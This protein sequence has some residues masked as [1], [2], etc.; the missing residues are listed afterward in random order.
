MD[1]QAPYFLVDQ[2]NQEH[3]RKF[4]GTAINQKTNLMTLNPNASYLYEEGKHTHMPQLTKT[5][6]KELVDSRF[7]NDM[8]NP[9]RG[10]HL[11]QGDLHSASGKFS[12]SPQ[13]LKRD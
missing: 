4:A 10:A 12:A 1:G 9:K 11:I 8:L 3:F 7:T 6:Q 5:V 13:K 2:M